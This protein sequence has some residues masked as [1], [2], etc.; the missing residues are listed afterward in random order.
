MANV[1]EPSECVECGQEVS[2][3]VLCDECLDATEGITQDET[4]ERID[5]ADDAMIDS[6]LARK[7]Y[8]ESLD[9]SRG[10]DWWD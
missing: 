7:D 3:G 2:S 4:L 9:V 5:S 6:I 10:T 1:Y 8:A